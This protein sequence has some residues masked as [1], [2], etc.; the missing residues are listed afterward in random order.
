MSSSIWGAKRAGVFILFT[1]LILGGYANSFQ[2]G[3]HFDDKPNILYNGHLHIR[4]L[5]PETLVATFYSNPKNPYEPAGKM[6]RPIPCLTLALNWYFGK[7]DPVGYHVVNIA[8]HAL[9][10]YLLFLFIQTLYATPALHKVSGKEMWLVP[11]LAAGLWAVNPIHTQ[12]VTYIVQR[13]T[14]MAA[15][16]YLLSLYAYLKARLADRTRMRLFGYVICLLCYILALG[17]KE[18]TILL[19]ISL[20][21]MEFA[22]FQ[23]LHRKKVRQVFAG[24]LAFLIIFI[25]VLGILFFLRGHASSILKGYDFRP[26]SMTQRLLTEM[27]VLVYYITQIFY[28]VPTRLSIEHDV[29]ISTSLLHPWT[30][31]PAGLFLLTSAVTGLAILGKHP[32]IGFSVLFFLINHVIESSIIPIELIFEH[33]NYLPSFFLFLPVALGLKYLF[34]RYGRNSL[35]MRFVMA[36][37]VVLLVAGYGMGTAIRNRVWASEQTLWEDAAIKAPKSARPLTNLAWDMAYGDNA[38]PENYDNALILYNKSLNLYHV[39]TGMQAFT[40]NN[41]AG[42]YYKKQAYGKTIELLEESLHQNPSGLKARFDLAS[43]YM[44]LGKW[45]D[46]EKTMQALVNH[47]KVHEGYLNQQALILLH[48]NR[49]P[50][51][52]TILNQALEM[53]PGFWRTLIYLGVA[54]NQLG[55]H[56]KAEMFL[57]RGLMTSQDNPLALFCLID[58]AIKADSPSNTRGY[59]AQLSQSFPLEKIRTFMKRAEHDNHLPPM[60]HTAISAAV[61]D[62]MLETGEES[63]L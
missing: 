53:A 2:A 10:A 44:T 57:K 40:L 13:M 63:I 14:V 39:R 31:L 51:A 30:T 7:D 28:A 29:V 54:F 43:V 6:Y 48:Q 21:V 55:Y 45:N 46:A 50:E 16:F 4:D 11:L 19:P 17:S 61:H 52:V 58:N 37:F 32:M 56:E 18:N 8:L 24:L 15:L 35:P 3:W 12:A 38:H 33:R 47:P 23:D 27:R 36:A 42:L 26:F 25:A 62:H 1:L 60:S 9:T 5:K 22:F 20:T 41:M 49:A 59:I 34:D